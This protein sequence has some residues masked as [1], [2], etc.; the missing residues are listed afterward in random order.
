MFCSQCGQQL[1][2][3]ARFCGNCGTPAPAAGPEPSVFP[4]RPETAPQPPSAVPSALPP[5]AVPPAGFN[6]GRFVERVKAILLTPKTE[7][8]VIAA[9]AAAP[10]SIYLG[11]VAPLVAIG[12]IAGFLGATLIGYSIPLAG[13]VRAG[14][15]VGLANALV[16]FAMT[17]VGVVVLALIVDLLAPTFGGTRNSL[18]AL[19]VAA[20]SLTPGW[21]AAVLTIV[22]ALGFIA[23]LLGLY[24]LYLLYLGL[25]VLM[26]NPPDK[27]IGY[28]VVVV[29][30]AIVLAI[31]IGVVGVMVTGIVG[32]GSGLSGAGTSHTGLAGK[33]DPNLEKETDSGYERT[34]RVDGNLVH[35]RYDRRNRSGEISMLLANRFSLE[36]SGRGVEPSVLGEAL[37]AIDAKMLVAA[38]K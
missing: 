6:V 7:W 27:S 25:P 11:Y 38:T 26:R 24:G 34:R 10:S 18:G 33:F 37:R 20:Y 21:V 36:A 13:T 9:E 2:D 32:V 8:P 30:C 29:I 15:V 31:V 28:T 1:R 17:F 3:G 19:K 5:G 22:P 4:P 35:E 23:A 12:V 16:Q 14:I